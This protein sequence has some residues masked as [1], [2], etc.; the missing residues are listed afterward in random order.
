M[1][2]RCGSRPSVWDYAKRCS[3]TETVPAWSRDRDS[4]DTVYMETAERIGSRLIESGFSMRQAVVLLSTVYT[5]TI[6][7]VIEEQAVF[8]GEGK[9][10]SCRR[11]LLSKAKCQTRS[12]VY[13]ILRQSGAILFDRFRATVCKESLGPI[14]GWRFVWA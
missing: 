3:T 6:S 13:L 2:G 9:T 12:C 11:P 4:I 5:F 7:F 10:F 8:P 1:T 14:I